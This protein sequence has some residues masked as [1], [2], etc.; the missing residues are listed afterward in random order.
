MISLFNSNGKIVYEFNNPLKFNNVYNTKDNNYVITYNEE[1]LLELYLFDGKY[2]NPLYT[3]DEAPYVK[4][5]IYKNNDVSYLIGFT[6]NHDNNLY[7]YNV[8]T[9]KLITLE[10]KVLMADSFKDNTYYTNNN[11]Y[12]VFKDKNNYQGIIDLNGNV[13]IEPIYNNIN[14]LSNSNFIVKNQKNQYGIIDRYNNILINCDYKV[15]SQFDEYYLIVN[16]KDKMALYNNDYKQITDFAMNY[17]QTI[18]YDYRGDQ[19]SIYLYKVDDNIIVIN[20]YLELDNKIEYSYHNMYLIKNNEIK[21]TIE[22]ISFNNKN[23]IY[24]YDKNNKLIIYDK[25]FKTLKEITL[26]NI[27][28]INSFSYI[29]NNLIELQ[30]ESEGLKKIY[31]DQN[32]NPINTNMSDIILKNSKYYITLE[33]K[34]NLNLLTIFD[35]DNNPL[36]NIFGNNIK[37][38]GEYLII[39]N[40]LY[41][42]MVK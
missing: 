30:Y 24:T 17:N 22:Q 31:Y 37:I 40:N 19:T 3:H 39:D 18:L 41:E 4:P 13:V 2:V 38:N 35:S 1:N 21:N 8:E 5:I 26:E 42:I 9:K 36:D 15:I 12:L 20:N 29:N 34:D 11:N 23:I 10:D 14:T 16:N 32:Y 7:I 33:K 28:K 6:F 25:H 27:N